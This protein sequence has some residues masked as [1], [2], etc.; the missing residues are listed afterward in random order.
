MKKRVFIAI[1]TSQ[2]LQTMI[3]KWRE[4]FTDLPVRWLKEKNLHLTLVPPWY[5]SNVQGI[6]K[7]LEPIGNRFSRIPIQFNKVTLGPDPRQPR[8]IWAE[9][10]APARIIELQKEL[11]AIVISQFTGELSRY[12]LWK[13]HLT[14]ARFRPE[15][16]N[17]S[18]VSRFNERVYWEELVTSI[19]LMESHLTRGGADYEILHRI[20]LSSVIPEV[21]T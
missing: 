10:R 2:D 16:F 9:G 18:R 17:N 6:I 8:L 13:L 5:T 21:R 3:L 7:S 14:L 19:V 11:E 20:Q 12:R 4:R 1:A 15:D